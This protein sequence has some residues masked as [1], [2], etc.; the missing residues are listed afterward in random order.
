VK[1]LE[2]E[3]DHSFPSNAKIKNE[4][5]YTYHF[6]IPPDGVD[7]DSFTLFFIFYSELLELTPY[8]LN[9]QMPTRL[10]VT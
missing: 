4:W 9:G 10:S 3:S 8:L 6:H 1:R 2:R 7:G 5:S